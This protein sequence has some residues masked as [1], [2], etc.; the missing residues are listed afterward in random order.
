MKHEK[1]SQTKCSDNGTQS[2][3]AMGEALFSKVIVVYMGAHPNGF[4][5]P[6]NADDE[7]LMQAICTTP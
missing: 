3:S 1:S 2:L 7:A 4:L 5:D 6:Y